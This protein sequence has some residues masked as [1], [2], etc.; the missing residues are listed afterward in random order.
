[1][2]KERINLIIKNI[3]I[4]VESLKKEINPEERYIPQYEYEEVIT[5]I[6]D[7]DEIYDPGEEV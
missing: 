1:M 4:L 7:Y 5:A 3:E 2:D 6:N